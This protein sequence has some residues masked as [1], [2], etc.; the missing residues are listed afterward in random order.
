MISVPAGREFFVNPRRNSALG[1]P[2]SMVQAVVE[3]SA[4]FTSM[5]IQECGFTNSHWVTTPCNLIGFLSSNSAAKAWCAHMGAAHI[6]RPALAT[7]TASGFL[8]E[9]GSLFF[10]GAMAA[11]DV[12]HAIVSFLAGIF[13]K[14]TVQL[15]H[16]HFA[17][18]RLGP[19]PW[20]VHRKLV[21]DI[22]G[23]QA[24]EPLR[25]LKF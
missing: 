9:I 21:Q 11:E 22:V 7:R 15:L 20:I 18:P 5:W 8:I 4:F 25:Y 14:R 2:P 16:R 23:V 12:R 24:R 19:G 10:F 1:L 17:R 3:P 13:V 6:R